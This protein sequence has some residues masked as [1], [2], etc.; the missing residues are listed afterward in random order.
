MS[1]G[2]LMQ[3]DA[4]ESTFM[5]KCMQLASCVGQAKWTIR[6]SRRLPGPLQNGPF[7]PIGLPLRVQEPVRA[8]DTVGA[9]STERLAFGQ[10]VSIVLRI[11]SSR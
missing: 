3:G 4:T 2:E 11:H 9:A 10:T 1:I 7:R 5:A 6:L 8:Y